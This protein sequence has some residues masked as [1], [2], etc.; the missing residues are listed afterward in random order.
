MNELATSRRYDLLEAVIAKYRAEGFDVFL[1]PPEAVLPGAEKGYRPAAIAIRPDKKIAIEVI[2]SDEETSDRMRHLR[3]RFSLENNW[4]LDIIYVSPGT[5]TP[6][7]GAA[8][9]QAIIRATEEASQLKNAGQE[10][11]ALLMGWSVLEAVARALLPDQ[12]KRPQT[13]AGL[14]EAL[15]SE[16]YVTPNEA[17]HLRKMSN[18]RNEAAHGRPDIPVKRQDLDTLVSTVRSLIKLLPKDVA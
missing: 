4:Q 17:D 1:E 14:I 18:I 9:A 3:G 13:P 10:A 16:G 7:I 12:L 2:R 5:Q 11:A 8:S 15:A 6:N